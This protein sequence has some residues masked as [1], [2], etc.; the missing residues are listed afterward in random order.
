MTDLFNNTIPLF[1]INVNI[2]FILFALLG[3]KHLGASL[4]I[5]PGFSLSPFLEINKDK[6]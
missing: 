4:S 1:F 5:I 3:P 6:V 2:L